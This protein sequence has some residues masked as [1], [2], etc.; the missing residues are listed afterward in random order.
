MD[1]ESQQV[2]SFS[3][4]KMGVSYCFQGKKKYE[5]RNDG[6]ARFPVWY[7]EVFK[8]QVQGLTGRICIYI[9]IYLYEIKAVIKHN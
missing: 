4:S 1:Q 9:Y 3:F 8:F 7:P 5:W 6:V 2:Y